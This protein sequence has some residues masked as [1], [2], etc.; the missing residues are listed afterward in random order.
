MSGARRLGA[1]GR[2]EIVDEVLHDTTFHETRGA[3]RHALV[4]ERTRRGT[5]GRERIVGEGEALVEHL[6]AHPGRERRDALQYGLAREPLR[7]REQ[8]GRQA[9]GGEHHWQ[10]TL[11]GRDDP[12]RVIEPVGDRAHHAL[13]R[14]LRREVGALDRVADREHVVTRDAPHIRAHRDAGRAIRPCG[15]RRV[16]DPRFG[17][18]A[19]DRHVD[20][21][22]LARQPVEQELT[23]FDQ[24]RERGLGGPRDVGGD[25][26]ELRARWKGEID[27]FPELGRGERAIQQRR[28][29]LRIDVRGPRDTDPPAV[30]HPQIHAGLFGHPGGLE[31]APLERY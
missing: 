27:F 17:H 18:F 21:A 26:G 8:H 13:E 20:L 3:R 2:L 6:L 12:Q 28:G 15:S 9:G 10:R 1:C 31:A 19:L 4:V 16:G 30:Q 24:A 11:G 22:P 14:V 29:M 5:A 7:D 23:D 25:A